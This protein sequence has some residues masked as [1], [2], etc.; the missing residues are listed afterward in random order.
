MKGTHQRAMAALAVAAMGVAAASAP[1]TALAAKQRPARALPD[2]VVANGSVR[3]ATASVTFA[4]RGSAAAPASRATIALRTGR[5]GTRSL[6]PFAV[7]AIAAGTAR[8]RR[9]AVVLPRN[10]AAGTYA[11]SVCADTSKRV[12]ERSER[13]NCR[14]LGRVTLRRSG[15]APAP[16]QTPPPAPSPPPPAPAPPTPPV[17]TPPAPP[18]SVPTAPIAFTPE[19][20]FRYAPG[21]YWLFVPS[22]YDATHRTPTTLF[23]WMHGCGGQAEGDTYMI[24]P[25]GAQSWISLSLGGRDGACWDMNSDPAKV[26]GALAD[27]KTHFNIA[28]RKVVI[29][30]YSSGG[31]LA[32]RTAFYNAGLFAGLL[33]QNTA[34]FRDTGSTQAASLAAAAWRFNVVHLAQTGDAVYPIGPVRSETDAMAAAGFPIRRI[35]QPGAHYD[36]DTDAY[37]RTYLLPQLDAGWLAP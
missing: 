8:T 12:D 24:S 4:N 9:V 3:G 11:A 6:Q 13:N 23:L 36:D 19:T 1:S 26:L 20:V 28:P 29:G 22:S 27:V 31:D 37:L 30:G 21:D 14:S 33:A 17:P 2:L 32:Y 10:L 16:K 18:S 35:E 25:G 15:P 5:R 7:P 34:P